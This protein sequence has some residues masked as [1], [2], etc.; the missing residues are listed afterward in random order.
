MSKRKYVVVGNRKVEG[1]S[2]GETVELD[3]T[4]D[5]AFHL[6]GAGHIEPYVAVVEAPEPAEVKTPKD[7][8]GQPAPAPAGPSKARR[9]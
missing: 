9:N 3:L 4:R 6:I 1:K 5:Q 8:V 2:K 7:V